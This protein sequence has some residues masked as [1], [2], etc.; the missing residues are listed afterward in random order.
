MSNCSVVV[1]DAESFAT[2]LESGLP[3]L[4]GV[5]TMCGTLNMVQGSL[6]PPAIFEYFTATK[7]AVTQVPKSVLG[8][9]VNTVELLIKAANSTF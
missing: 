3:S 2:A 1:A 4:D 9:A 5:T 7:S 8:N 6:I